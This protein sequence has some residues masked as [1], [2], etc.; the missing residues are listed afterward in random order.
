VDSLRAS[1][2]GKYQLA[3]GVTP[4]LILTVN[5]TNDGQDHYGATMEAY[6]NGEGYLFRSSW[7]QDY[8]TGTKLLGDVA[9]KVNAFVVYGWNNGH[10]GN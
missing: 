2:P 3:D 4:N 8:V 7:N 9:N 1:N 6:G 5:I 10:C